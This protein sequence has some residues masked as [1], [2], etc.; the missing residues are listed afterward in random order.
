MSFEGLVYGYLAGVVT[1]LG[2][3]LLGSAAASLW[4][5]KPFRGM[6]WADVKWI[7]LYALPLALYWGLSS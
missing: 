1:A 7:A 3:M 5:G 6:D 4:F 2:G